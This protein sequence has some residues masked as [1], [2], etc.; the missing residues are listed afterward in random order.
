MSAVAVGTRGFTFVFISSVALGLPYI[1]LLREHLHFVALSAGIPVT[2]QKPCG[3]VGKVAGRE[4]LHS[5]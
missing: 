2:L 5:L 1:V 4:L 3:C